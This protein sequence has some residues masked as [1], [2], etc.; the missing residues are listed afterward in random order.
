MY[1]RLIIPKMTVGPHSRSVVS[2][3][4]LDWE[5]INETTGF[6]QTGII[7]GNFSCATIV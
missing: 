3:V 1:P 6:E 7:G 4:I 5:P 2:A